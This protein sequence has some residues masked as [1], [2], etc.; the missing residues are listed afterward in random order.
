MRGSKTTVVE[1][2]RGSLSAEM[3]V[4]D[5]GDVR[6]NARRDRLIAALEQHPDVSFPEACGG[7]SDVEAC[8]RFLRNPRISLE[9]VIEPHLVATRAR[10]Q[11]LGTVLVIHDTTEMSFAGEE[12]RA[13]LSRQS[14]RRQ[15]FWVHAALAVSAEGLRTPLGL[16]SLLPFVRPPRAPGTPPPSQRARFRDPAKESRRWADGVAAV[17][18]RASAEIAAVH[19]M[20][21]EGDSYEL[22]ATLIAH[23]DRFVIRLRHD[24]RVVADPDDPASTL[25]AALRRTAPVVERQ[26][27]LSPRAVGHRSPAARRL[28]PSRPGRPA[29]LR[30]AARPVVLHR[31]AGLGAAEP[32]TLAVQVVHGWEVDP[33]PGEEPVDWQLVTTEPIDTVDDV[34]RIVDWYRTRWLIEEYFKALKTGCA[35]EQR[36]LESLDTLLVALGLLT[37]IAWQLLLLRHL[38]RDHA[39]APA[40]V[41]FTPHRL[42][43]LR[44]SSAGTRLP[45]LPTVQHALLAVARLGGHLR[46][47]GPPGWLVLTRGMQTLIAM[48]AG[49]AA[50]Q[51][52]ARSDQS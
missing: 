7:A 14:P 12:P 32:A 17:R 41:V 8:Y 47:N 24:R 40:T 1:T 16:V 22:L 33:P 23:R 5:L 19:L 36:Q 37:P 34:L 21:R 9:T 38:S 6:L 39:E 46:Q 51:H 49:W 20:D 28:H 31:P 29:T 4:G 50:A 48:E 18:A 13:G 52:A 43:V 30:F 26:V 35:Y 25:H 45:P 2:T 3:A 44:A 42:Q 27:V 15:G 11:A 10:C